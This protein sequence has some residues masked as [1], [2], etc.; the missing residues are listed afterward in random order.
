MFG[1]REPVGFLQPEYLKVMVLVQ[2]LIQTMEFVFINDYLRVQ[3]WVYKTVT[4]NLLEDIKVVHST[5]MFQ[6][7]DLVHPSKT[8]EVRITLLTTQLH[9][10]LFIHFQVVTNI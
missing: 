2:P 6:K 1:F 9:S 3:E 4:F 7:T 8:N 5:S 10:I